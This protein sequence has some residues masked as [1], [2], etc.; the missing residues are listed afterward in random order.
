MAPDPTKIGDRIP[1]VEI[2]AGRP[3]KLGD[4]VVG[5]VLDTK[6]PPRRDAE[7]EAYLTRTNQVLLI[8]ALGTAVI[9]L[10][11]GSLLARTL[12]GSLREMTEPPEPWPPGD[13]RQQVA[14]TLG[15][16]WASWPQHSTR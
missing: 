16:S 2:A 1:A 8:G 11:L 13:L 10:L 7:E 9:A 5:A 15:T 12:T 6:A 14:V 4:Q 3:I